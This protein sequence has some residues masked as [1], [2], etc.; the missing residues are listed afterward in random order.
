M[1]VKEICSMIRDQETDV[2]IHDIEAN[3]GDVLWSGT[4][5]EAKNEKS[6]LYEREVSGIDSANCGII[7]YLEEFVND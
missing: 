5:A 6:L 3:S 1:K 7:I 4:A 2:Y